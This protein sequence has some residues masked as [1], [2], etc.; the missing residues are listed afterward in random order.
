MAPRFPNEPTDYRKARE[1]LLRAETDL[2]AR[3]EE[4]AARRRDLPLGGVVPEDYLFTGIGPDGAPAPVRLSGLFSPG[5]DTLF[6]YGFMFGPAMEAACPMCTALLDGLNGNA[7]HLEQRINL[8][9]VARSPIERI[10][11]HAATR[12]WDRLRLLS[13]EGNTYP[14]DY[15]AEDDEGNPWPMANVFLR[16]EGRI[17]HFWGSELLFEE[18]PGG[19]YRH[20]DSFWP[21]WNVLDLTPAGRGGSWYPAL[22]YGRG[23][24]DGNPE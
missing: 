20:V 19:D 11:D 7:V 15:L 9:V 18:F 13:S 14:E 8:G 16:R 24:G 4:V 3:T 23:T 12:G 2:R 1:E 6:L 22:D 5:K 21:L 10:R 17:H